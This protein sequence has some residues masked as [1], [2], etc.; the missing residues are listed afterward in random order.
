[1]SYVRVKMQKKNRKANK[2]RQAEKVRIKNK[3]SKIS[4]KG[5]ANYS[6]RH[7]ITLR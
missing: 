2:F 5:F 1:M 3:G 4:I 6:G 7:E